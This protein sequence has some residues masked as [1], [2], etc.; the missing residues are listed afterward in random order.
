MKVDIVYLG[1][2]ESQ[3]YHEICEKFG[4]TPK[5]IAYIGDDINDFE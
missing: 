5:E 2:Q 1:V 3:G 4:I